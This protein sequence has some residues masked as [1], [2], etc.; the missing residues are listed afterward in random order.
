MIAYRLL[1]AQKQHQAI[2]R[3]ERSELE[4]ACA[5]D[6]SPPDAQPEGRQHAKDTSNMGRGVSAHSTV[7]R[8]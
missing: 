6:L 1:E 2:A 3:D 7:A 5:R 8:V 4:R